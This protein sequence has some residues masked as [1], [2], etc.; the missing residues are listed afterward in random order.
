V[1]DAEAP[2]IE[3]HLA[4]T[5]TARYCTLGGAAL[6]A[7]D[8]WV[9]CHG[10]GQLARDFAEEF[11]PIARPGR[12]IV[13]PEA[14]NRF[15]LN[16]EGGRA[17][18]S[19][20]VG[21]TWMT[22]EDRLTEIDDYVRYLDDLLREI[23]RGQPA[24]DVRVTALG[25]SQ[26]T[27]TVARWAVQGTSRLARVILWAG[28]LPPEID[29]AALRARLAGAELHLVLGTRDDMLNQDE[30]R[31]GRAALERAAVPHTVHEFDGGHRMDRLTLERLAR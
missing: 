19:A 15:Y 26:G 28:S 29:P 20:R 11:R 30:V 23:L 13:A 5:R 9:V 7:D 1:T 4:V 31:N 10:F 12:L 27:A 18:A 24:D 14:L 8:V 3:H 6:R 25:F 16:R 17:G 2:I 21:A 22:R